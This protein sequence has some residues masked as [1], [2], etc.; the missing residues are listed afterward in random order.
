VEESHDTKTPFRL[1]HGSTNDTQHRRITASNR[2]RVVDASG[3]ARILSV[4]TERKICLVEPNTV[5]NDLFD[6]IVLYRPVQLVVIDILN[7]KIACSF[8]NTALGKSFRSKFLCVAW[9]WESNVEL[10]DGATSDATADG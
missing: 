8:L 9:L 1:N 5:M 2:S 6:A 7:M 10:R 3:L 4:N